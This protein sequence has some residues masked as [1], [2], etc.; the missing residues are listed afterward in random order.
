[1]KLVREDRHGNRVVSEEAHPTSDTHLCHKGLCK[2]Q[3]SN[4]LPVHS[5]TGKTS[6][7]VLYAEHW[8]LLCVRGGSKTLSRVMSTH[9]ENED[10]TSTGP[11]FRIRVWSAETK[12]ARE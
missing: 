2:G 8:H 1:M 10:A 4:G 6:L 11:M 3:K 12:S 5:T 7:L 9:S